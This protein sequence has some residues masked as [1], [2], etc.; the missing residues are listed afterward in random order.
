MIKI[1]NVEIAGFKTAIRGMRH[2]LKSYAYA[3]SFF[4]DS[5][6]YL[7]PNDLNLATRLANAG[8]DHGK[9]LRQIYVGVDIT[10]P[11]YWWKEMDTYKV[12]TVANSTSTMHRLS[13]DPIDAEC[14]SIDEELLHLPVGT[15][16]TLGDVWLDTLKNLELIRLRTLEQEHGKEYWRALNQLLPQGWMQTRTWTG[17]Y[18]TLKNIYHARK[19]HKLVEWHDFCDWIE[20]LPYAKELIIGE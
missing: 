16:T 6:P 18:A 2:P 11:L 9:F 1:E 7:G 4:L 13:K 14:F 3:D 5:E 12:A 8:S 15:D 10:A 20:T 17:N 19:N